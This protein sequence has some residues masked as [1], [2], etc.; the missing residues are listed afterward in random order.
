MKYKCKNGQIIELNDNQSTIAKRYGL[1]PVEED[2]EL[3]TLRE[4]AKA[5]GIKNAHSMKMETLLARIAETEETNE[6][7]A[8]EEEI[9]EE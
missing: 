6:K 1:K 9:Y 2:T 5:L 8:D 4:Q 3:E 7:V